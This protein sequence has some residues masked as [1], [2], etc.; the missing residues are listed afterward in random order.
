MKKGLSYPKFCIKTKR[1]T[2]KAICI[3]CQRDCVFA[4]KQRSYKKK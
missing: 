3:R 1:P 4:G 2:Q